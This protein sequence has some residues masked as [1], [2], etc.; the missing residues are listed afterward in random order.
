MTLTATFPGRDVGSSEGQCSPV[1]A[2][3]VLFLYLWD[4]PWAQHRPFHS[5]V[6]VRYSLS[7]KLYFMQNSNVVVRLGRRAGNIMGLT[8]G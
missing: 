4:L 8:L 6:S 3:D 5:E 1:L 2:G 7:R